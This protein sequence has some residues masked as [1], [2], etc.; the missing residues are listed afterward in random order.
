VLIKSEI[1]EKVRL[2]MKPFT[3][4]PDDTTDDDLTREDV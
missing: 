4:D 3:I 1:F 2:R